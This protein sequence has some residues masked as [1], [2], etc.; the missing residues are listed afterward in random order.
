MDK[1]TQIQGTY[2]YWDALKGSILVLLEAK[3]LNIKRIAAAT[4]YYNTFHNN[5]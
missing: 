3:S 2:I 1:T 4:Y 5:L